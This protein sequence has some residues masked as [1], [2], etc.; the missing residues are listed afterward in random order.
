MK[1]VEV[2]ND[3]INHALKPSEKEY[4]IKLLNEGLSERGGCCKVTLNLSSFHISGL[5]LFKTDSI[6]SV[7]DKF[8]VIVFCSILLWGGVLKSN[9][10]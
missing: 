1:H 6:L 4:L 9:L 3:Y 2:L 7:L 8:I 5:Q 10:R